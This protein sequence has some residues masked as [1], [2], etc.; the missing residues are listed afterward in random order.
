MALTSQQ[1]SDIEIQ[2]IFTGVAYDICIDE[3]PGWQ[4]CQSM[5]LKS[6]NNISL[7][8]SV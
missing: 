7:H 2:K 5:T 3:N 8:S 4:S 6:K 1:M